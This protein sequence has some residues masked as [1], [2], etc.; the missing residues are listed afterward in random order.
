MTLIQ[1]FA[2]NVGTCGL[3]LREYFK[4]LTRK[5]RVPMQP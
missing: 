4:Q 2:R 3:M 5:K 1:A